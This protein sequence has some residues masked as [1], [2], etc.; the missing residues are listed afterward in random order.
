MYR[1]DEIVVY[2]NGTEVYKNN[3]PAS[4]ITHTTLALASS[5]D[6]GKS[7]L[8]V[9]LTNAA[10]LLQ[11]GNNTIAVEVHQSSIQSPDLVWDMAL[12]GIP[13]GIP[14]ITRGPYLQKATSSSMLVRWYTDIATDSK[15]MYGTDPGNLSQ[16]VVVPV[17]STN[18][19]VQLTGLTPYTKYYY[20][21][22]TSINVIQSGEDYHFRT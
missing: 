10:S 7:V 5:S 11:S 12:T 9:A 14:V 16:S 13:I 6:D 20:S 17:N 2:I 8:T 4:P 3:M 22:G 15:V 19:S 1:D 18:H 21:I